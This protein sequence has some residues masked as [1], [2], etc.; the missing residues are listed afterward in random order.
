[1]AQRSE[2]T[3]DPGEPDPSGKDGIPAD[4]GPSPRYL[5]PGFF[6]GYPRFD[7]AVL[8]SRLESLGE[9][10]DEERYAAALRVYNNERKRFGRWWAV[11]VLALFVFVGSLFPAI[12]RE[13]EDKGKLL[14]LLRD[15]GYLIGVIIGVTVIV[16]L[17]AGSARWRFFRRI[18]DA[19]REVRDADIHPKSDADV[20]AIL[21]RLGS[22]ARW[23]FL[24]LQGSRRS[25]KSPPMVS[26][27]AS[28]LA[29]PLIDIDVPD[30]LHMQTVVAEASRD[31]FLRFL[32]DI[33]AVVAIGREDLIP[34]VRK[35]YPELPSRSDESAAHDRD[36][37]YLNP[38]RNRTRWDVAKD[39]WYPLAPWLSLLIAGAA[40]AISLTR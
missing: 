37:A 5:P 24:A 9:D 10:W 40:L 14:P 32:Q 30:N 39:F 22:A 7:L 13:F 28:R 25:W 19:I 33:A 31:V 6:S 23:L 16:R 21:N 26:D 15:A 11:G 3:H 35:A 20:P 4:I 36:L 27:R 2:S 17:S 38:M 1:M 34:R 8:R 12:E 29:A 18:G